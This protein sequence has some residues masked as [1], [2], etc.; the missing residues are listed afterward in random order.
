MHIGKKKPKTTIHHLLEIQLL[1][2]CP[3]FCLGAVPH[4]FKFKENL[5][6]DKIVLFHKKTS[7]FK[8]RLNL[9]DS[10]VEVFIFR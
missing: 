4:T 3:S 6:K 1:T 5:L 8:V 2:V 9:E 7:L 10:L